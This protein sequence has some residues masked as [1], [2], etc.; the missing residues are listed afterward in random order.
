MTSKDCDYAKF[1]AVL[2]DKAK[3]CRKVSAGRQSKKENSI[4]VQ[5]IKCTI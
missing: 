2:G 3:V 4:K 1:L 5:F